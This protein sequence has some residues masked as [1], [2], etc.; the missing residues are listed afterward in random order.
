MAA[1]QDN[2]SANPLH[3][4]LHPRSIAVVG[5]SVAAEVIRQSRKAG[6]DGEI[7]AVNSQRETLEGLPCYR[8]IASLPAAP[9]AAFLA[10]PSE[11]NIALV[12]AL[13]QRGA[14]GVVCYASGFAELGGDGVALQQQLVAAAGTM[15]L[16]GPNCYGLLNY[17]ERCA[18]WPDRHGGHA[19]DR[20]VA[21]LTQSGNIGL[22]LTMQNRHLPLAYL[23]AVGNCAGTQYHE[24][25]DAL[26]DDD[27]V[28]AIGLH[29]ESLNDIAA[30]SEVAVRALQ[31]NIPIVALKTG[32][33]AASATVTASHT[34]ALAGSDQ[35]YDA[36]FARLGIGRVHDLTEF[37][38]TLKLLHVCGSLKGKAVGSLSCSGGDAAL[39]A[40]LAH[41]EGL[42]FPPLNQ[43]ATALLSATL[44]TKVPL[45]NPLDYHTY[46]WGDV[47]ALTDCFRGM[48]LAPIDVTV[49]VLD[50]PKEDDIP[51]EGWDEIVSAYIAAS[52]Q[53]RM[54]AV[55]VSSLPELLPARISEQLISAGIAP[56]QGLADAATAIRVAAQ[57]GLQQQDKASVTK[58]ASSRIEID[59]NTRTLDE[60]SAKRA[61]ARFG[62]AIPASHLVQDESA[63]IVAANL[64]GYPVVIKAVSEQMAHKTELGAVHLNIADAAEV[65]VTLSRM[66]P[67]SDRFLIERMVS[68]GVAELIV[69]V[70]RDPQFGLTLTLGAG[71]ILVELL[72][73][74]V[75]LLL[76]ASQ[77]D[78]LKA[79]Q[80]LHCFPLLTGYRGR[81]AANIAAVITAIMAVVHY[82]QENAATLLELDVNPLIVTADG[83]VAVDALITLRA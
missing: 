83:A 81:P 31:K 76:P 73:D 53:Q 58:V 74:A 14:G 4:L 36:L 52:Q 50:Y 80:S 78:I 13:R 38:E 82:A 34:S 77:D 5:G 9:D 69:G 32:C 23:I 25:I 19:V 44:G 3:R 67:L 42:L 17:L 56:I 72:R 46:I 7:W 1:R 66:R 15:P 62:L 48:M 64:L 26:L 10:V 47:P 39:F 30:F 27:R 16:V 18:L 63:A 12:A 2:T 75:T 8:D 20:G 59:A 29:I 11:E 43:Q 65:K 68:G 21:I 71:G 22:N 54:P 24:Y 33:S 57:I 40:D 6:F 49:L 35:L 41:R 60:F 51:I 45:H 79:L 70:S 55:L 37:V 61:L 28:S